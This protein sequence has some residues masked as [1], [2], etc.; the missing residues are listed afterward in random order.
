MNRNYF[1]ALSSLLRQAAAVADISALPSSSKITLPASAAL[2]H[3]LGHSIPEPFERHQSPSQ[4][5]SSLPSAPW[6]RNLSSQAA[7]AIKPIDERPSVYG[8]DDRVIN[9]L[10]EQPDFI[11]SA[12]YLQERLEMPR[13]EILRHLAKV[14]Y[15]A[16]TPEGQ[17]YP[18]KTPKVPLIDSNIK[19]MLDY[20][21]SIPG[22]NLTR[23]IRNAPFLLCDYAADREKLD[24]NKE[25]LESTLELEGDALGKIV[26]SN[27]YVLTRPVESM[28]MNLDVLGNLNFTP[29][30]QG[31]IIMRAPRL[32]A[33][34]SL[35]M[36]DGLTYFREKG[37]SDERIKKVMWKF[38]SACEFEN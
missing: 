2:L 38:P 18:F 7:A 17:L 5:C 22:V 34:R 27:G 25:W 21:V 20:L 26:S 8:V 15:S 29:A 31:K 37:F 23:A 32:L 16:Y 3:T 12:D 33:L 14:S 24:A 10:T 9:D 19:P 1:R 11:Q 4:P 28:Q 13:T 6:H 36:E 30:Q 35:R